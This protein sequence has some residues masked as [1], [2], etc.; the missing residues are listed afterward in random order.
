MSKKYNSGACFDFHKQQ[1]GRRSLLRIGGAGLLGLTTPA[2]L[3]AKAKSKT[4]LKVRAKSVIFLYQFGGPSHLDTFDMKPDAPDKVR[5]ELKPMKTVVPG[6]S[7]CEQLPE[8]AKVMDKLTVIRSMTHK[9]KNHNSASYYALTGSPPPLDDIRLRNSID[10]IPAYGSV[11]DA[12]SPNRDAVP[13]FVSFPHLMR[14]GSTTPGQSSSFLGKKHAPLFIRRDPNKSDFRLPEL[15]LPAGLSSQRIQRRRELQKMIDQQAGLMESSAEAKGLDEFYDKALQMITSSKVRSA[16]DLSKESKKTRDAYGRHTY[17]QSCLLARRLVEVGVKFVNVYFSNS[18][19]GQSTTSGGWDTHGRNK[20]KMYPIMKKYHLP[21][22]NQTLPT[23]INDLKDR[24]LLDETLIVWMGEFGRTPRINNAAS[25][26]H[27]PTCYTTVLAGG[28]TRGG[29]IYGA[30][31]HNGA[32]VAKDPVKPDDLAATM[33]YLL[34]ID[35]TSE[36]HDATNR[37]RPIAAGKLVRGVI[38]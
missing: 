25:R 17:G 21:L 14:D 16:F 2:L 6:V 28:G 34:G 32:L 23:L 37:P 11:V 19:G 22:T 15:S 5:G 10:L 9:M 33:Y 27:W 12:L 13:G 1:L 31:D 36:I 18:I 35:P 26:D 38:A 3:Q 7:V 20:K 29:T 8:V 30:S 4:N 24:G